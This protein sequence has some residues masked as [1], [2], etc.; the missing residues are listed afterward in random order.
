M[1][2]A[3]HV[4]LGALFHHDQV[5]LKK[6]GKRLYAIV[7]RTQRCECGGHDDECELE[8]LWGYRVLGMISV[9]EPDERDA[10]HACETR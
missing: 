10:E 9:A 1:C 7:S 4:C 6:V 3:A 8:C 5:L 2:D